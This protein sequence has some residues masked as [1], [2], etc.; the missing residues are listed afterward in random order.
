MITGRRWT[1]AA[2]AAFVEEQIDCS[3]GIV[4]AQLKRDGRRGKRRGRGRRRRG[5][6]CIKA[7]ITHRPPK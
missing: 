3:D 6:M 2:A 5:V 7:P 1:A 4:A